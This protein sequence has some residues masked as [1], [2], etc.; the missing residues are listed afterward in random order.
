VATCFSLF[1]SVLAR[2]HSSPLQKSCQPSTNSHSNQNFYNKPHNVHILTIQESL[3]DYRTPH[4]N[5]IPVLILSTE[6]R[7]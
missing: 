4:M 5:V 3:V 7:L 1:R 2:Q 6:Q